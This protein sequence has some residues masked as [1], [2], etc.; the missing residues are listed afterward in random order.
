MTI[1]QG[2][3][4]EILQAL[5][6][7]EAAELIAQLAP[8]ALAVLLL[9][10]RG[11]VAGMLSLFN[12]PGRGPIA[13]DALTTAEE[14]AARAGLALDNARLYREQRSL[15]EGLQRSLLTP[16][17]QPDHGQIVVRVV[18]AAQAAQ[19]GGDWYDAFLQPGGATVL[20]IGDVVGHDTQAAAAMG[21]LR[22]IADTD[23]WMICLTPARRA[24]VA[25]LRA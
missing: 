1:E 16:P 4:E 15:A 17:P 5:A 12:G 6:S 2:A 25:M 23:V 21:Q 13:A 18:P 8:E 20:V 10:G 22:T 7:G 19:V 14:I 11:R 9:R 24:A 3:T